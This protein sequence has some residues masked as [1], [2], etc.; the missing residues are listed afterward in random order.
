MA[1]PIPAP[2]REQSATLEA[3]SL[4]CTR[5]DRVLF[6]DLNF[7]LAPSQVMLVEGPN[8]S[9]KTTLLRTLCGLFAPSAGE[10]CWGGD[11]IRSLAE[12]FSRDVIY[13]GHRAGI[14]EELTGVE[15]LRI[16]S[17]LDGVEISEPSAWSAL[18]QMGLA[19]HEDLPTKMLSAGQK[20]RVALARLLITQAPLWILD[21]PFT[22]LD[23]AAVAFLQ[24]IIRQHAEAGGIVI[25][26]T[27][28]DVEMISSSVE[29]LLLQKRGH[30]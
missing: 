10:V 25:L 11:S 5:S 28:Q 17:A 4:E 22:A 12:E 23:K 2:T 21:E 7:S 14:K 1:D 3:R 15:N 8:G 24:G 16:S 26:T 6:S 20:R 13:L 9:G 30:H 27:H 18:E 19:G 29:R